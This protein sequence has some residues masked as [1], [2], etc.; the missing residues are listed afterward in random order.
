MKVDTS[1]PPTACGG[2]KKGLQ[3]RQWG[4]CAGCS[5]R[6]SKIKVGFVGETKLWCRRWVTW[7]L[8]FGGLRWSLFCFVCGLGKAMAYGYLRAAEVCGEVLGPGASPQ[9]LA[10]GS[11]SVGS[12]IEKF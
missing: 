12:P 7:L 9:R 8:G 5:P 2:A 1:R 11:A 4:A 10:P 3:E 6:K